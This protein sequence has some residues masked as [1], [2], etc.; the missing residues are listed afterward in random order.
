MLLI[1]PVY[2]ARDGSTAKLAAALERL[3]LRRLLR[4]L[5]HE[6]LNW[7]FGCFEF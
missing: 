4:A 6:E 7:A 3:V 1:G 2:T 5:N